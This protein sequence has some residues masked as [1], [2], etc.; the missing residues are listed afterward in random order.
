MADLMSSGKLGRRPGQGK[1][2]LL[3]VG[4]A[5]RYF[6]TGSI[7]KFFSSTA[8]FTLTVSDVK[9]VAALLAAN[10]F[11]IIFLKVTSTLTS[12][13]LEAVKSIRSGKKKNTRL[14]FVFIK[15]EKFKGCI[16]D[17]GVDIIFPEPLT[18]GKMCT[19]IKYW[20]TYFTDVKGTER[21]P[22]FG[23]HLKL[24]ANVESAERLP[25]HRL[26]LQTS[27]SELGEHFSTDLFLRS[28]QLKNDRELVL[29]A[30]LPGPE[31]NRKTSFLHSSK[32]KLRR[33]RIKFC[34]EQLRTLLPYVKGRKSD[35]A[36]VIEATVDYMKYVRENI[37]PA[38]MAQITESLQSNKRFSKRQVPIELFVPR[39]ATSQR[40]SGVLTSAYSSV[41]EIQ[42]LADQCLTV[43]SRPAEEG[44]LEEAVRGQLSS[45]SESSIEDLYDTRVPSA[46]L[47]LNSC[48]AV[49]YCPG[50]VPPHDS[51]ARTNQNISIYLPS[52][53]PSVSDFLP[54]HCSSML[55]Q[56]RSASPSCLCTPGQEPPAGSL[57]TSSSIF[58]GFQ[59]SDSDL[60]ASQQPLGPAESFPQPQENDYF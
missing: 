35:V 32:E 42:L 53:V 15:P 11:D 13:E 56:T 20:K 41:R 8:H 44:P 38:I 4:D 22:E 58:R 27:C 12:E 49:T 48:H 7:Q 6:L 29:K 51:A 47:S 17:Y 39:A 9:K 52:T 34:C 3:L 60:Q 5:T 21:L 59:D 37:S 57:T 14:L 31:R 50:A 36:S 16:S 10:S 28:G 46:A 33:E 19:V 40:D 23:L 26:H 18:L 54:Q 45:V 30:P 24:P 2:D 43:Y 55:C 1:V 25:E